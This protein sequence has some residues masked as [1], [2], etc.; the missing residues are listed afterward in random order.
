MNL[1]ERDNELILEL[2]SDKKKF[3]AYVY[4]PLTV[5]LSELHERESNQRISTYLDALSHGSPIQ[6]REKYMALFRN[7]ATPNYEMHRFA[8]CADVLTQLKPLILE[9]THDTFADINELKYALGKLCFY[10]GLNVHHAPVFQYKTIV[11]M[12]KCNGRKINS[13]DTLWGQSFVDLHHEFVKNRIPLLYENIIDISE[14]LNHVGGEANKYYEKFF[15]LFLRDGI[16][17][18]TFLFT[19]NEFDF[20][21]HTVLPSIITLEKLTGKKPLIVALEPT[22]LEGDQFW[23]SYP[24]KSIDFITEKL[25]NFKRDNS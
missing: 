13:L 23:V 22:N 7:I 1:T 18:E 11:D 9:Y 12:S 10:K 15:S 5:A 3:D 6:S 17:F 19:K 8:M 21:K 2:L 25:N 16:L 4:T 24:E 14:W 20:D